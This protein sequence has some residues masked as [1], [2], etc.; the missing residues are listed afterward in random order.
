MPPELVAKVD[1]CLHEDA[2]G[3]TFIIDMPTLIDL[4]VAHGDQ[5]P[6]LK[7]L[8]Q[9]NEAAVAEHFARTGEVPPGIKIVEKAT[10]EGSNV[11]TLRVHRGSAR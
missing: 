11:T 2:N 6:V 3:D 7:G 4:I 5:Y 9:V 10:E 1:A 8:V